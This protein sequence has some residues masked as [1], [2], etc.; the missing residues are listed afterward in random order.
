MATPITPPGTD[1][2]TARTA[3]GVGTT[4]TPTARTAVTP[5]TT[6]VP[7]SRGAITPSTT[8]VPTARTSL[9]PATTAIPTA[10]SAVTPSSNPTPTAVGALSPVAAL[11]TGGDVVNLDFCGES[12]NVDF[13]YSRGSAATYIGR[14][15]NAFNQYEYILK[16]DPLTG[17]SP[18][19]EYDAATGEC[20]GY[21]AE[22]ASTNLLT[23]NE[24]FSNPFWSATAA[25]VI[26][27]ASIA[28]DGTLSAD[29]LQANSTGT[30]SPRIIDT[31][32]GEEDEN[33]T[34]S[35]YVKPS[36]VN[37]LQIRF[38]SSDVVGIPRANFDL[39]NKVTGTLDAEIVSAT[40][41]EVNNNWLRVS[42][43]VLNAISTISPVLQLITTSTASS[44]QSAAFTDGDGVLIW[45]AQLEA[46]PFATSYIRTE[47]SAVT[48]AVDILSGS[49][50]L[51]NKISVFIDTKAIGNKSGTTGDA[52]TVGV[53]NNNRITIVETASNEF[54][55][56]SIVNSVLQTDETISGSNTL[57]QSKA[58][59]V[60]ENNTLKSYIN[61][62]LEDTDLNSQ[63]PTVTDFTLG[64]TFSGSGNFYGHIK[65]AI[66]YNYALTADEVK[67]L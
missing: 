23:N 8:P 12:Y 30:I 54:R 29:K 24:D 44:G 40:I 4:D 49:T 46:L 51:F 17:A 41:I 59:F 20:L 1:T 27:N 11:R 60:N 56:F 13:T 63:A 65:K 34:F 3:E 31:F 32:T 18:R 16:T 58:A 52:I 64:I 5:A 19:I 42:V 21:L 28:P 47:G 43:T 61:N 67:A 7:T 26:S 14:Q 48:R 62:N 22:G 57:L 38:S 36:G 66:I 37:F 6:A 25:E 53:D 55:F 39:L 2:P 15:I 35:V 33:V 45:G 50:P 10:R 9:T